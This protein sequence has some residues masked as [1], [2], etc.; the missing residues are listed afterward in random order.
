M[1]SKFK[2]RELHGKVLHFHKLTN[3]FGR[4]KLFSF[5]L[6][7][8]VNDL[9]TENSNKFFYKMFKTLFKALTSLLIVKLVLAFCIVVFI[10][11]IY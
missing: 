11:I 5:C 1:G 3:E 7:E 8:G 4:K 9:P 10:K 6:S 2:I